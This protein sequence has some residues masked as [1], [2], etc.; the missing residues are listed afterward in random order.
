[1][2]EGSVI[3]GV[4]KK[5]V[6]ILIGHSGPMILL[7]LASTNSYFCSVLDDLSQL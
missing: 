3:D 2:G 6:L 1:M 5:D 7:D 4:G